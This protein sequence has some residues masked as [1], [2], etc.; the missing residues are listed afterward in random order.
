MV[1]RVE[2]TYQGGHKE[3]IRFEHRFNED[4]NG[5]VR[6][7]MWDKDTEVNMNRVLQIKEM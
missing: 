7:R 6:F 1:K 2:V 5:I 3:V 4:E